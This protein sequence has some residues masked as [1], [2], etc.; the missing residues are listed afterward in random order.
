MAQLQ[1]DTAVKYANQVVGLA[2]QLANIRDQVNALLALNSVQ[3][4]GNLWNALNTTAQ[5]A[6]GTLGT[7]DGAPNTAHPID[8]RVYAALGKA[9]S[10]TA[11]SN[12]LQLLTEFQTFSTG[13]TTASDASRPAF[14]DTLSS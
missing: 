11:L 5:A 14:I 9:V 6:D 12:G 7:A 2:A 13:A 10:A 8:T 4:L 1:S 3:P